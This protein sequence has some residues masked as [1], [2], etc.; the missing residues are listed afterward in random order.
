MLTRAGWKQH[1]GD[2][3]AYA[4]AESGNPYGCDCDAELVMYFA[5]AVP[6]QTMKRGLVQCG[7]AHD[8][9]KWG[10][11]TYLTFLAN[12][13]GGWSYLGPMVAASSH[14]KEQCDQSPEELARIYQNRLALEKAQR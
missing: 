8:S 12:N 7:E 4:Q 3:T 1:G 14:D 13:R 9:D 5:E 11:P 10:R 2:F 6:P